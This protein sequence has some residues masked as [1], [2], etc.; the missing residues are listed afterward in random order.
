MLKR[1]LL[2]FTQNQMVWRFLESALG[3]HSSTF[4]KLRWLRES[5]AAKSLS[6]ED[7]SREI[8]SLFAAGSV[9]HGPFAGMKYPSLQA[10][11][12]TMPPKLLGSYER[13]IAPAIMEIIQQP[14]TAVVDIGCA[15]G[16]Y[17]VGLGMKLPQAKIH[18]FD[19]AQQALELCQQMAKANGVNIQTGGFCDQQTLLGLDLGERALIFSDCEGYELEL[20]DTALARA[21]DRH[22][23]LIETHDFINPHISSTLL[24]VLEPTHHCTV[25]ESVDDILKVYQYH[26]P[27]IEPLSPILRRTILAEKRPTKM[28]WIYAKSLLY[29]A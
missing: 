21:I 17:A 13:E 5:T 3:A 18:A 7:I 4:Y 2:S 24:K 15:E 10:V 14:Y 22:D 27:E 29:H 20:F 19:T 16:Y 9:L 25:F 28:R 12:S 11:S 6:P 26:Y 23:C 1:V 8:E